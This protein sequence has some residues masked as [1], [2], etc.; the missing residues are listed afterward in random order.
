MENQIIITVE[1]A[2]VSVKSLLRIQSCIGKLSD[3]EL[4]VLKSLID[5]LNF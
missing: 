2:E 3:D 4:K 1:E 5:K